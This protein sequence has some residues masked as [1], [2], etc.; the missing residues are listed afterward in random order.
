[1]RLCSQRSVPNGISSPLASPDRA[2][3]R[4]RWTT[5]KTA[6]DTVRRNSK[7]TG[8]WH[9]HR[10]T[11]ITDLAE[12]GAGEQTIMDIAGHVSRNMLKHY[13]HIRMEAKRD[14]LESLVSKPAKPKP[15]ASKSNGFDLFLKP[16]ASPQ[17]YPF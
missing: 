9:D 14:A 5:L 6:W 3:R 11:L 15:L 8:R 7:V 16:P 12:S 4:D 2:T 13:S 10:H 1:M 17:S